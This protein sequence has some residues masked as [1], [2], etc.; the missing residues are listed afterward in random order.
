MP[1]FNARENQLILDLLC[2]LPLKLFLQPKPE[3]E[4]RTRLALISICS[5]AEAYLNDDLLRPAVNDLKKSLSEAL[6]EP[7]FVGLADDPAV[8][9]QILETV[10]QLLQEKTTPVRQRAI[11]NFIYRY[12]YKLAGMTGKEFA[13]IG[14]NVSAADAETLLLIKEVLRIKEPDL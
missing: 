2:L 12:A 11:C 7:E 14:R 6:S 10:D 3:G 5:A 4:Q 1:E 9:R 13:N 8:L